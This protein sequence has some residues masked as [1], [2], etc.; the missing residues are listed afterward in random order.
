MIQRPGKV[1]L[2]QLST[3]GKPQKRL[4]VH[5][6]RSAGAK[7]NDFGEGRCEDGGVTGGGGG[8]VIP[9]MQSRHIARVRP[10]D[11]FPSKESQHTKG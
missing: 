8:R 6:W 9:G 3:N 11:D 1:P 7:D 4:H 2:S 10:M 5:P